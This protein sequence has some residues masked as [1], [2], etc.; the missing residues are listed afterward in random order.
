[1]VILSDPRNLGGAIAGP[2]WVRL[3]HKVQHSVRTGPLLG[4]FLFV[5]LSPG[6]PI[7]AKD[8]PINKIRVL[9]GE[10]PFKFYNPEMAAANLAF[11]D[12]RFD[13]QQMAL[14]LTDYMHHRHRHQLQHHH[15]GQQR[16]QMNIPQQRQQMNIPHQRQQANI[17]QQCQQVNIPHAH[18]FNYTDDY[19]AMNQH[20]S[21]QNNLMVNSLPIHNYGYDDLALDTDESQSLPGET[22]N[23]QQAISSNMLTG[24]VIPGPAMPAT[25]VPHS[26]TSSNMALYNGGYL[27]NFMTPNRNLLGSRS[28]SDPLSSLFDQPSPSPFNNNVHQSV[29]PPSNTSHTSNSLP[30]YPLDPL[31]QYLMN[32]SATSQ[33]SDESLRSTMTSCANG[34]NLYKVKKEMDNQHGAF[35]GSLSPSSVHSPSSN[36]DRDDPDKLAMNLST[37]DMSSPSAS[38]RQATAS[39][40]GSSKDPSYMEKRRK[41]N[42]SAK[43]S[44]EA[45]RRKEGLLAMRLVKLEEENI[46]LRAEVCLLDRELEDLRARLFN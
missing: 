1:M 35:A 39:G 27:Q 32:S 20:H 28:G 29:A 37:S 30:Q 44:R 42:E 5:S 46:Q 6:P 41:N 21:G 40:C 34:L 33:H 4:R 38:P 14:T 43:R 22:I 26:L 3:L 11:T 24:A 19:M 13:Q 8:R 7:M 10:R 2:S 17:P 12:P 36:T 9:E 23:Q 18:Q 45:R 16:Q 15:M 25:S 31:G